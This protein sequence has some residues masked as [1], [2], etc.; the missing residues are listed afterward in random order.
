MLRKILR[1]RDIF[2][3]FSLISVF[4]KAMTKLKLIATECK[5]LLNS[6]SWSDQPLFVYACHHGN[7]PSKLLHY[8]KVISLQFLLESN[9]AI[10]SL[11]SDVWSI[12]LPELWWLSPKAGGGLPPSLHL[13]LP[14]HSSFPPVSVLPVCLDGSTSLSACE[15]RLFSLQARSRQEIGPRGP[16]DVKLLTRPVN[17]GCPI[18]TARCAR[19]NENTNE[20]W[21]WTFLKSFSHTNPRVLLRE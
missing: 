13:Y 12:R 16:K 7:F 2:L 8:D 15:G 21:G 11:Y 1:E 3:S 9:L 17:P 20:A 18:S 14:L 4:V 5:H 19:S 10:S 6:R